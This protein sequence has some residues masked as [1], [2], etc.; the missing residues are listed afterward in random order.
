MEIESVLVSFGRTWRFDAGGQ[1]PVD[2]TKNGYAKE[3]NRL[4]G[5]QD[6]SDFR[7]PWPRYRSRFWRYMLSPSYWETDTNDLITVLIPLQHE[8]FFVQADTPVVRPRIDI[9]A[10]R[11]P[12]ALTTI[13][14]F[15]L[16][17]LTP[18]PSDE[19]AFQLFNQLARGNVGAM[20]PV[21]SGFPYQELPS[22]PTLDAYGG[23]QIA[24]KNAGQFT[25]I[26]ALYRGNEPLIQASK[27]ARNFPPNPAP[28]GSVAIR[29]GA[30][31]VHADTVGLAVSA[32]VGAG[33]VRCL[34][35]NF[36][37]LLSYLQNLSTLV[38]SNP[39]NEC[40]WYRGRAVTMLNHL[41]RAEPVP[42][43]NTVYKTR[44]ADLWLNER[45]LREPINQVANDLGLG[46]PPLQRHALP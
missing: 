9:E 5:V 1:T 39:T 19:Q 41:Y 20:Q 2:L 46:L 31:H 11:H 35:H 44:L 12:F 33:K 42:P 15:R 23:T 7:L 38:V 27:L 4:K 45:G 21:D 24:L 10:L 17:N 6:Q 29:D 34:H 13:A 8:R 26:S 14:H 28:D 25:V 22:F 18:W 43:V 32:Q 37:L 36:T 16:K 30:V 3:I 40:R